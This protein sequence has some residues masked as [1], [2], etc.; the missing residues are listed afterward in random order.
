MSR[1]F[2]K[3]KLNQSPKASFCFASADLFSFPETLIL[4]GWCPDFGA[5]GIYPE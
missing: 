5:C 3:K 4:I 2:K 1:E